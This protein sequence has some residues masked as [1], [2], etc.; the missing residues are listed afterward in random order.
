MG[1]DSEGHSFKRKNLSLWGSQ[2]VLCFSFRNVLDVS[3]YL[4]ML[5][6]RSINGQ[7]NFSRI[8]D[9]PQNHS[10][11]QE[12]FR[13]AQTR[14]VVSPLGFCQRWSHGKVQNSPSSWWVLMGSMCKNLPSSDVSYG[15]VGNNLIIFEQFFSK[16]LGWH[17]VDWFHWLTTWSLRWYF[18]WSY[19]IV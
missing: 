5:P 15:N 16:T 2:R 14:W 12:F 8:S 6:L 18:S 1:E 3:V 13:G 19:R 17:F 10:W 9:A 4:K 11:G 7:I